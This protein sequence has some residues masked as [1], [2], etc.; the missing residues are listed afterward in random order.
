MFRGDWGR[1][2]YIDYLSIDCRG[3]SGSH[4]F[5][6]KGVLGKVSRKTQERP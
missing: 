6:Q 1:L 2:F 4:L 5:S 3:G